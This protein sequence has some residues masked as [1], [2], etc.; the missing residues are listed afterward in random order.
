MLCEQ[1]LKGADLESFSSEAREMIKALRGQ[2]AEHKL[3]FVWKELQSRVDRVLDKD[4]KT[5]VMTNKVTS[6]P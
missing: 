6:F 1:M 2:T 5:S 3:D 4:K